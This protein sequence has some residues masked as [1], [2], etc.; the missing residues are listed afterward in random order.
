MDTVQ[1]FFRTAN[2][3]NQNE[4]LDKVH[5]YLAALAHNGQVIEG[6]T[7][8]ARVRGGYV[9]AV[10]VPERSALADRVADNWVRKRLRELAGVGV[11]RPKVKHLGTNPE[12][13]S[14]DKAER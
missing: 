2:S 6:R 13:R 9:V 8:L 7:P 14:S 10:S 3:R 1:I 4:G 11:E 5:S 12:S